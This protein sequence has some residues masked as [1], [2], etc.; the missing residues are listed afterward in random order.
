MIPLVLLLLGCNPDRCDE[1]GAICTVMGTDAAGQARDG[2]CADQS[3]LYWPSDVTIA[4][5][6]EPWVLDW[7]NHRI[8]ALP[9]GDEC[10]VVDVVSGTTLTGDGPI[11]GPAST[12]RWNHP[13]NLV[14]RP[15]GT[16]VFAAWHQ[17]RVVGIDPEAD[18]TWL[19]AGNGERA[20]TGDGG[21]AVDAA[22]D[23]P[24][25]IAYGDDGRLYVADQ[26]NQ[27][28][29]C[30]DEDGTVATVIGDGEPTYDG[31]GGH[32]LDASLHSDTSQNAEP[33]GR[34]TI[35]GQV[36]YI[37]DTL[38]MRVRVVDMDTWTI[39]TFAGDGEPWNESDDPLE[40]SL[41]W[42]RDVAVGPDGAVY[43]ADS[44]HHCVRVVRDGT[45]GT[46]AGVCGEQGFDGDE[47]PGTEALLSRPYGIDVGPDGALWIAD[48]FNHR[49]RRVA[50]WE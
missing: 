30:V 17:S 34:I 31:D 38:N 41:F 20:F 37:A 23:L 48:T 6:G 8:L 36:M 21:P 35:D 4:P 3:P 47:G 9:E 14:L 18:T 7:N 49:L 15:D 1:P 39:D 12:A 22:F 32:A 33:G 25:G 50:P 13:T 5:N 26:A 19:V 29:R 24:V 46:A 27:R 28:V 42:P 11:G 43:I 44:E 40:A 16:L 2:T 45:I 10:T